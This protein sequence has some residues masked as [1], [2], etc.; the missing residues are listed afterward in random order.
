MQFPLRPGC[1]G[2]RWSGTLDY[3]LRG[4]LSALD[5]MVVRVANNKYVVALVPLKLSKEG[6]DSP[7]VDKGALAC[8][9]FDVFFSSLTL[10]AIHRR[11]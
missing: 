9:V 1:L 4:Q 5:K 11:F 6:N 7:P 8:V 10:I 2:M 3:W